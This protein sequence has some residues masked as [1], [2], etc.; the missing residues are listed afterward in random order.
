[1][2]PVA[3]GS[4]ETLVPV[5]VR[6]RATEFPA[7]EL[8][9][10]VREPAAGAALAGLKDTV[11]VRVWPGFNAVGRVAP[12]TEYPAPCT[13]TDETFKGQL[14][15]D[16]SVIVFSA[17]LFTATSP[18]ARLVALTLIVETI[19]FRLSANVFEVPAEVAVNVAVCAV[20]EAA[21]EAVNA[22]VAAPAGTTTEEGTLT[23]V[24]LLERFTV[25]PPLGAVPLSATVQASLAKPPIEVAEQDSELKAALVPVAPDPVRLIV[26]ELPA[27][28]FVESFRTP[29]AFPA[30]DGSN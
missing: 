1:M 6:L 29:D 16:E 13:D 8:L 2:F 11:R 19:A 28:E 22:A 26:T 15:T 23:S 7:E 18:K 12:D 10:I 30:A 5:P 3:G 27:E 9:E 17:S 4:V 25:N 21:T 14:P 20:P 24:L